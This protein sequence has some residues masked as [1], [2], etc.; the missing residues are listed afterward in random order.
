[1]NHFLYR[2]RR[3]HCEDVPLAKLAD[4]YGTPLY[5]YSYQTIAKHYRRIAEAWRPHPATIAYSMKANSNLSILGALREL[6]SAVDVVSPGEIYRARK[7]GFRP[8]QIIYGGVGKSDAD[9][10]YAVKNRVR[11]II[12]DSPEELRR[13]DRVS[14]RL[15]RKTKVGL[16]VNP[17]IGLRT[18][19][20]IAT[21]L[22][23][24]KFGTPLAGAMK[25]LKR[26]G[27][28]PN[29]ELTAVHQHIG[30]QIIELKPFLSALKKTSRLVRGLRGLGFP[31]SL[32]D[33]GGGIGITYR[34]EKP[35]DLEEY[36]R[37]IQPI[38]RGL[39]CRLILEPGRVIMGNAG[40]LLTRVEYVKRGFRKYFLIV[41]AAMTD[42]IRPALYAAE[43]EVRPVRETRRRV[44]G[45]IVGPV[46]ETGDFLVRDRRIPRLDPGDLLAVMSCGAYGFAMASNYNSRPRAAEVLIRGR[47]AELIRRRERFDDLIRGENIGHIKKERP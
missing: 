8:D 25:A 16:R 19:P 15:D 22:R 32:L 14:R 7:A 38:I 42:L 10:A 28:L 36:A 24:S 29:I 26:A 40:I 11:L 17:E 30:S 13:I 46:C 1:M 6:G 12:A 31:I 4:Q 18:H 41:D 9:I 43:H 45:D 37:Q 3:L 5:V 23:E 39:D 34:S 47:R 2:R 20:Y 27:R 21:G 35:F 44:F 33:I